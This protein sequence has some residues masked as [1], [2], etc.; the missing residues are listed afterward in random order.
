[1]LLLSIHLSSSSRAF[2]LHSEE[3]VLDPLASFSFSTSLC[4]LFWLNALVTMTT[5]TILKP[6]CP[7]LTS[8]PIYSFSVNQ[9][10]PLGIHMRAQSIREWKNLS[11][12]P[13]SIP[14]FRI[15]SGITRLKPEYAF[16]CMS[17]SRCILKDRQRCGQRP[18]AER[19]GSS[20]MSDCG[21]EPGYATTRPGRWHGSEASSSPRP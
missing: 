1:M 19:H 7:P 3:S 21:R 4:G 17:R 5:L 14:S 20:Q 9:R 2:L 6:P 13:S 11:F 8:V 10:P 12:C 18:L 16:W 15:T